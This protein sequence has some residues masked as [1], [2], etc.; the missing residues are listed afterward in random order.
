MMPSNTD[1]PSAS[2]SQASGTLNGQTEVVRCN[3]GDEGRRFRNM[4]SRLSPQNLIL[5]PRRLE[6]QPLVTRVS[7]AS[8]QSFSSEEEAYQIFAQE[9][10]KGNVKVVGGRAARTVA[11]TAPADINP[12]SQIHIREVPVTVAATHGDTRREHDLARSRRPLLTPRVGSHHPGQSGSTSNDDHGP[13]L[14]SS[15]SL[16]SPPTNIIQVVCLSSS[17]SGLSPLALQENEIQADQSSVEPVQIQSASSGSGPSNSPSSHGAAASVALSSNNLVLPCETSTVQHIHCSACGELNVLTS[18]V[19]ALSLPPDDHVPR[20][21]DPR[22]PLTYPGSLH[23]TASSRRPSPRMHNGGEM[24]VL[25][26]E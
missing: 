4:V 18:R 6:V 16:S 14:A 8:H 11:A 1:H 19:A 25:F 22:S 2:N 13:A 5:I 12:P 7:D 15:Q 23:C 17:S 26:S 10:I 9:Q 3:K 20:A 21:I 24:S